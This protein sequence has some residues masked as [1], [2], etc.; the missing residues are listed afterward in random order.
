MKILNMQ[1]TQNITYCTNLLYFPP[2]ECKLNRSEISVLFIAVC[3]LPK[4]MPDP[5]VH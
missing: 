3:L 1:N 5:G 4:R 2:L